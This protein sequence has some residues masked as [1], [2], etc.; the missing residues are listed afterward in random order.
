MRARF[1]GLNALPATVVALLI[2]A[3][4]AHARIDASTLMGM[5][6][7]DENKG[8]AVADGSK[9]AL[10]GTLTGDVKWTAGKIGS[11]VEFR[12]TSFVDVGA[13]PALD[14]GRDDLSVVAWFR[15]SGKP[16]DWHAVLVHKAVFA[17]P[18]HGYILCVRGNLDAGNVGKPLWWMGLGTNDG[19][20]LF[21]TSTINDGKWHHLAGTA[22]RDGKM[23]LYRDGVLESELSIVDRVKENEDNTSGFYIGGEKATRTL[24]SGAMDEVAVFRTLLSDEDIALI[25]D[26]GLESALG[27]KPVSP[28][29]RATVAWGRL[30]GWAR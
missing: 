25:A 7:F 5:W 11:G 21:G 15:Y 30:K 22:D 1:T 24:E 12:A 14:A 18:R 27:L 17:A 19:I 4:Q 8:D 29:G 13:Q 3:S 16:P 28:V 9:N 26:R 23:R 6:L 2:V 10:K 20:H